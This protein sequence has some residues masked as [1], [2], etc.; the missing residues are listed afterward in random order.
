MEIQNKDSSVD[1]QILT[2]TGFKSFDGIKRYWHDDH[3]VFSF[4]DGS[5]LKAA[6]K[7]KFIVCGKVVY[8]D[9]VEVGDDIGKEVYSIEISSGDYFY[10]PVNVDGKHY[11]HDGDFVSHNTFFGTGDTLIDAETLLRLRA[12]NPIRIVEGDS[13]S[14][15]QEPVK[16]HEYIMLV[17]VSKGRGQDYS[18]F[19]VIDISVRPFNQVA[20]YRNNRISPILFPN[21]I[22]KYAKVFNNA[23]V[24]IEANDQGAVVCNGLYY[25]LEYDEMHVS[26][27]IKSDS[28]GIEMNRKTKRI[29]CSGFKDILETNRLNVVDEE[30]IKEISTF[31]AKGQSYEASDGNHDDLVMNLVM[32]GY[33]ITTNF[34]EEMTDIN[35]KD[36]MFKQK[37]KEIEEDVL[38]FGFIDDGLSDIPEPS[39]EPDPW[40]IGDFDFAEGSGVFHS[41]W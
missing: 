35:I 36:M 38:P 12:K 39:T 8:A 31:V 34:F 2:P 27:A 19:N 17:D 18:T 21:V 20:V 6:R 29:G 11:S 33:F 4:R 32:F 3:I 13:V 5:I 24:I 14:I 22:H 10:D 1:I 7:H 26:S 9:Q 30:T 37:M 40:G 28:L 16:G 23:Y 25:D 41:D 15:Y